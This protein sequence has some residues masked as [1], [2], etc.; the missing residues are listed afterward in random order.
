MLTRVHLQEMSNKER[1]QFFKKWKNYVSHAHYVK[2]QLVVDS[3]CEYC[4]GVIKPVKTPQEIAERKRAKRRY[5]E[6]YL[7]KQ[8]Q[9]SYCDI[10]EEDEMM[11]HISSIQDEY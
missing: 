7:A 10:E 3:E 8:A 11:R 6:E 1:R 9:A 2:G 4:V 5:Y